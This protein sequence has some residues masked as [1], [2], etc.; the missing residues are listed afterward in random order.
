MQYHSTG[1]IY[2]LLSHRA[3]RYI[4]VSLENRG[5]RPQQSVVGTGCRLACKSDHCGMNVC[6]NCVIW[7]N[8]GAHYLQQYTVIAVEYGAT[9]VLTHLL[10]ALVILF[11][12]WLPPAAGSV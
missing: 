4:P 2:Q 3:G 1:H 5:A 8:M 12:E 7:C 6:Y 9:W 11:V 10:A